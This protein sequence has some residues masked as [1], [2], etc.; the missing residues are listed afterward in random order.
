MLLSDYLVT[1]LVEMVVHLDDL[2]HSIGE[3][4]PAPPGAAIDLTLATLFEMAVARN[5][6]DAMMRALSRT[7]RVAGFPRA[8]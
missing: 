3:D 1:R 5:G 7:E 4:L 8:F 2:A 6:P